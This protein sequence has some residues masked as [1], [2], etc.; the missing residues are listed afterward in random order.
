MRVHWLQHIPFEGLGCMED[1]FLSQGHDLSC[2]RTFEKTDLPS[3]EDF[4]W[5]VVMG[6]PMGVN[7]QAQYSWLEHEIELIK[8]TLEESKRILGICLGAQF[9]AAA[10]GAEVKKNRHK[11]IGWFPVDS[12]KDHENSFSEIMPPRF[13]ALHWHEDTFDLPTNTDPIGSTEATANQG[14][15]VGSRALALQFHLELRPE[16]AIR[17]AQACP[18]NLSPGPYVQNP[19]DFTAK[20][21]LFQKANALLEEILG[22]QEN[23][24]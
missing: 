10:L 6:G 23:G 18:H 14:F 24:G 5:L 1:W 4:D 11:E 21:D 2:T 16:D 7:D 20:P 17:I 13:D 12:E 3:T 22:L 19:N 15:S 9:M 8:A